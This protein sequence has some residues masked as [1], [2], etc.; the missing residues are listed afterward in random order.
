[1]RKDLTIYF[2][3][4]SM[5]RPRLIAQTS[6]HYPGEVAVMLSMLPTFEVPAVKDP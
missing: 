1:M 3:T 2:K 5:E 4:A 6:D